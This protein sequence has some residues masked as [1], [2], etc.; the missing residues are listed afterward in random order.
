MKTDTGYYKVNN[1]IF[2]NKILAILEAQKTGAEVEWNFFDEVFTKV[3]WLEEPT[4]SLKEFYRMRALQI[5]EE[6]DYVIIFCSGGADSTNVVKSFLDNG[7]HVDEV[8]AQAPLEGLKNWD[9]N[10]VDRSTENTVSETKFAQLPLMHEIATKYPNVRTTLVDSFQDIINPKTDEWLLDCQGDVINTWT[11]THGRLDKFPRLVEMAENGKKIAAVM[12]IDKPVLIFG[13]NGDIF[14]VFGD[15]PVNLPK[16]PFRT[17]YP[18]VDRK[19]F[20]WSHEMPLMPI[21]QSHV[22]ARELFKPENKH[23]LQA[24]LDFTRSRRQQMQASATTQQ[25]VGIINPNGYRTLYTK[26][27]PADY[28]PFSE[29]ERGIV[30]FIYPDTYQKDLFQAHKIDPGH[31]FFARNHDW[32]HVLHGK[33]RAQELFESDFMNFY[34]TI[35]PK[36]LNNQKTGF[37]RCRKMYR[38]GNVN[39]FKIKEQQ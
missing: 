17:P 4:T 6:Y 38:I 8:I 36:Y 35:D 7:I 27:K 1:Q 28:N 25:A 16:S 15:V 39:D 3:N 21:K 37:M 32:F 20:Y 11:H 22:V 12:G 34:K 18:N 23:V 10:N 13:P 5:R 29:Y 24:A 14:S 2:S 31:T 30:P 33:T 26:N 19:L 9:W